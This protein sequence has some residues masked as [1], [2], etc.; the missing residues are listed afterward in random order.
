MP[1]ALARSSTGRIVS[2]N[3]RA[4]HRRWQTEEAAAWAAIK[5]MWA[6]Q[7]LEDPIAYQRRVRRDR[8]LPK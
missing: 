1:K 2:A 6:G 5:G 4:A 8:S 3:P 7:K